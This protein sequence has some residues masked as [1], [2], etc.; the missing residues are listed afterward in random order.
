MPEEQQ[1]KERHLLIRNKDHAKQRYR[2]EHRERRTLAVL[3]DGNYHHA[4]GYHRRGVGHY[5]HESGYYHCNH[6]ERR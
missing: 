3:P 2:R 1:V 6:A 4:A 5:S